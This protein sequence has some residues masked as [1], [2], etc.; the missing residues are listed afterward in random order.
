[1]RRHL[2]FSLLIG[3][4]LM[5]SL[6]ADETAAPLRVGLA[7]PKGA[8]TIDARIPGWPLTRVAARISGATGWEVFLEPGSDR[9]VRTTFTNLPP[10]EALR[11]LLGGLNFSLQPQPKGPS[12]LYIYASDRD[13]AVQRIVADDQKPGRIPNEV[14]VRLKPNSTVTIEEIASAVGGRL[15]GKAPALRAYRLQFDTAEAA[16]A[17]RKKIAE[18]TEVAATE[19]NYR[20]EAPDAPE[21]SPAGSAT[22]PATGSAS[23]KPRL[24]PDGKDTVVGIIDTAAQPMSADKEAFVLSRTDLVEGRSSDPGIWHGTAMAEEFLR[25]VSMTDTAAGGSAVRLR[26]YNA[27]GANETAT[28]FDVTRGVLRAAEDG[29]RILS[30]SLGGP[31]P[32]PMLQEALDSFVEQ[33]GLVFVAAG[34]QGSEAPFYPA[35]DP[36]VIAVTAVNRDGNPMP[37]ANRGN[38]VDVGAP[39]V[40]YIPFQGQTWVVRGTSPATAL[41]AGMAAGYADRTGAPLGTVRDTI[42]RDLSFQP[43]P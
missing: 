16:E 4:L 10:A 2:T 27:Y 35:A 26:L 25:G 40:T 22:P 42:L 36:R 14:I 43:K 41:T 23:L 1:M 5:L 20:W 30:L 21:G 17:A 38:Y 13:R 28:S 3:W 18:M 37:W 32:S 33:G 6:E 12:R 19:N 29:A 9:P 31:E 34:N 15:I 24:T 8:R 7:W 11:R 39:G